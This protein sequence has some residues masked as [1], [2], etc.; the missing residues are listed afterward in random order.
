M[1][2]TQT[3]DESNPDAVFEDLG[4]GAEDDS[5]P[6]P[7]AQTEKFKIGDEEL[8]HDEIKEALAT[9]RQAKELE[10]G[11]R[12]KFDEAATMRQQLA[13][14]AEDL[15]NMRI[16]WDAWKSGDKPTQQKLIS[17]LASE[18]GMTVAQVKN[19]LENFDP[20][21][22]TENELKLHRQNQALQ[23]RQ[24]ALEARLAQLDGTV[25]AIREPLEEIR[26]YTNSEKEAKQIQSDIAAIKEKTG[27]EIS[28]EQIKTWRDNG[29]SDPVKAIGVLLPMLKEATVKGAEQ[30]RKGSEIPAQTQTDTFDPDDP[31]IDPDDMFDRLVRRNQ[32]PSSG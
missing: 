20:N 15:A 21:D 7:S 19:E 3:L 9:S 23:R 1:P 4:K 13:A 25:K 10:K 8:T 5:K 26:A 30:A 28:G 14:E 11:A 2:E 31:N 17:E 18:A 29:I 27:H 32:I 24:E 12:A 16:I 6:E 22:L